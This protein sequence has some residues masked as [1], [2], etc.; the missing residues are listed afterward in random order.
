MMGSRLIKEGSRKTEF[1]RRRAFRARAAQPRVEPDARP[2]AAAAA[3]GGRVARAHAHHD[4]HGERLGQIQAYEQAQ[5]GKRIAARH[6]RAEQRAG[7]VAEHDPQPGAVVAHARAD[8]RVG[9]EPVRARAD[10]GALVVRNRQ[11]LRHARLDVDRRGRERVGEQRA[12]TGRGA[13]PL[14]EQPDVA[15]QRVLVQARVAR[16]A[17]VDARECVERAQ[18]V[19]VAFLDDPQ[20]QPMLEP[21]VEQQRIE[22]AMQHVEKAARRVA[23]PE[24][25]VDQVLGVERRQRRGHAV[26]TEEVRDDPVAAVVGLVDALDVGVRK[27]QREIRPRV[28]RQRRVGPPR[29]VAAPF[30]RDAPQQPDRLEIREVLRL[31]E[32]NGF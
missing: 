1:G 5:P 26:Q 27:R 10:A 22:R 13:R 6:Q 8:P 11:P 16:D 28:D 29:G 32:Q 17:R 4:V 9:A 24:R 12:Q 19:F 2:R 7:H 3:R 18:R 20:R 23:A 30:A 14:A 15:Q 21:R 25:F 31:A